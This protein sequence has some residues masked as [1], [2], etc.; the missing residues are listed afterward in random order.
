MAL[1][2]YVI[3]YNAPA[4]CLE[5]VRSLQRSDCAV[6]VTVV[7]NGGDLSG[8][9]ARVVEMPGNVGYTG[10]ANWAIADRP[11]CPFLVV[12]SH[13]L[14]VRTETLSALLAAAE[15]H[16]GA[17]ILGADVGWRGDTLF[18]TDEGV[19]WRDWT[20]GSCLLLR[21]RCLEEIGG[22]DERL[23]SYGDDVDLATRAIA[24]GWGVG[25]V[26]AAPADHRGTAVG[27][28]RRERLIMANRVLLARK[29]GSLWRAVRTASFGLL[30]Q[31]GYQFKLGLKE[32][33]RLGHRSWLMIN[34][35]IG[36]F[37]GL[38]RLRSWRSGRRRT[39]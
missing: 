26:T 25:R 4:W 37:Q 31:M 21:R 39:R 32:P 17:G 5:T 18:G 2:V 30:R 13:D 35:A 19:E 29:H 34:E 9:P 12:T 24:A 14:D 28:A 1:P 11:D 3:H 22:F 33:A 8:L 16:P 23:H 38:L 10:A 36:A 27:D 7:N 20:S 6:D 15:A